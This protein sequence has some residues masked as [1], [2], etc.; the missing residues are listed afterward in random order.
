[1]SIVIKKAK[2]TLI[3]PKEISKPQGRLII[4]PKNK[5]ITIATKKIKEIKVIQKLESQIKKQL[6]EDTKIEEKQKIEQIPKQIQVVQ[7][8]FE[9]KP[10]IHHVNLNPQKIE[11][12][13]KDDSKRKKYYSRPDDEKQDIVHWGQ[14][15][16]LIAETFFLTQ[17]G[18]LSKNILYVGA[19]PGNHIALLS[20]LF[21]GHHLYLFDPNPFQVRESLKIRIFQ[22]AFDDNEARKFFNK[23]QGDYILISDI[24]TANYKEMS[25]V[26][27]EKAVLQDNQLQMNWV[28]ILKPKK[29]LLK[30][31]CAYPT[32]IKEPTTFFDGDIF[33]QPWA[34]ASSTETRLIPTGIQKKQYDNVKYEE[35]MFYHNDVERKQLINGQS[36]DER[37]EVQ[38]LKEYIKK[39]RNDTTVEKLQNMI[40]DKV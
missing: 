36:W 38:I 2:T 30:F 22:R 34:P 7:P 18:E 24:R 12:F 31:R 19:A 17:Y 28:E 14:R 16:L 10:Q 32:E 11:L 29:S 8:K 20:Q 9:Q 4:Q 23:F 5:T 35:Q 37:A 33:I 3:L 13:L 1:M 40:T 39:F 27:N 15:K 6:Q 21:R 26:E 25:S